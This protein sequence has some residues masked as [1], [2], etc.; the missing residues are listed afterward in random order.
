MCSF[1]NPQTLVSDV[2]RNRDPSLQHKR[3]RITKEAPA[4]PSIIH[5]ELHKF[6][7]VPNLNEVETVVTAE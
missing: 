5:G 1:P 7:R 3:S 4:D 2:C 6:D